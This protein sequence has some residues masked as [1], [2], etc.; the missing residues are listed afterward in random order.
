MNLL[1]LPDYTL[2]IIEEGDNARLYQLVPPEGTEMQ[3]VR[4]AFL[5]PDQKIASIVIYGD[6]C[7]G[8][9]GVI[10]STGYDLRWFIESGGDDYLLSKFLEKDWSTDAM[11]AYCLAQLVEAKE[12]DEEDEERIETWQ[13]ICTEY[14]I[15]QPY[16]SDGGYFNEGLRNA[17]L[18]VDSDAYGSCVAYPKR[19]AKLLL[20]IRATFRALYLEVEQQRDLEQKMGESRKLI[21]ASA[22]KGEDDSEGEAAKTPPWW[23]RA[24]TWLF[25]PRPGYGGKLSGGG[26]PSAPL[27]PPPRTMEPPRKPRSPQ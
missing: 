11:E 24:F 6:L 9:D 19:D 21:A 10:S 7:P 20:S 23:K 18:E 16:D 13:A 3:S 26:R 4:L 8:R 12:E 15:G 5:H 1:P 17:I 27:P 2:R 25:A 14:D 22:D